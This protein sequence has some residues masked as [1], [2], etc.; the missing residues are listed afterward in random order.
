MENTE[1]ATVCR[2]EQFTDELKNEIRG[3]LAAICHGKDKVD[4]GSIIAS[5][6]ETLK[7]FLR[8]YAGKSEDIRK[9]M[10]GELLAHIL[11]IKGFPDYRSANPYF[12]MEESSVKKGFDIIVFD[13][14]CGEL[15]IAEVKSGSGGNVG[16]DSANKTLLNTAKNDLKD[17][18]N[19]SRVHIWMNAINGAKLALSG[20]KIKDEINRILEGCY[21]E[22]T[23]NSPDSTSKNVILVSV[24]Y[25]GC[26]DPISIDAAHEKAEKIIAEGLFQDMTVFSIQKETWENIVAFLNQEAA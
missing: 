13:E 17:R 8:I 23:N 7:V 15:K 25:R 9:G 3:R 20:G 10:I 12:N 16:A 18:L 6:R 21:M 24:L 22:A 1:L 26:D 19:D 2:V 5:Y 4:E 14:S 11:L